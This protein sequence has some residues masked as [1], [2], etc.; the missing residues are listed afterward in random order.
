LIA[1]SMA[2]AGLPE[3]GHAGRRL[4]VFRRDGLRL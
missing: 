2:G 1:A 3:K 4:L